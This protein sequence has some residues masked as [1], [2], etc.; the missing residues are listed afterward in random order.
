M[1]KIIYV[2]C[3]CSILSA[4]SVERKEEQIRGREDIYSLTEKDINEGKK[5]PEV[6]DELGIKHQLRLGE[7]DVGNSGKTSGFPKSG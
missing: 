4:C 2:L 3:I 7:I 1:K 6:S 5:Y